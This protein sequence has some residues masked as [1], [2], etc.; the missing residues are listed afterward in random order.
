MNNSLKINVK[1]LLLVLT[2]TSGFHSVQAQWIPGQGLDGAKVS[3]MVVLDSLLF[4]CTNA[5]GLYVRNLNGGE[6]Q[7]NTP[8]G[9]YSIDRCGD[10]LFTWYPYDCY[11]S[12][13]HGGTWQNMLPYFGYG[14]VRSFCVIDT[15]LFFTTTFT[16]GL[17][18][19]S[20]DYGNT[21]DTINHNLPALFLPLVS[22]GDSGMLFCYQDYPGPMY[23][24][25]GNKGA[26]WDSIPTTGLPSSSYDTYTI[27]N[28]GSTLWLSTTAGIFRKEIS[29]GSWIFVQD[30][31]PIAQMQVIDGTLFATALSRGPFRFD[32]GSGQW[33][34]EITGLE[35]PAVNSFCADSSHIYLA[36]RL[37]PYK[38]D[39]PYTWLPF[40]GGLNQSSVSMVSA[41]D[42]EVWAV[43]TRGTFISTDMGAT[44]TLHPLTGMGDPVRLIM[45]DS[46]YYALSH[47]FFYLSTDH[48]ASWTKQ[49]TGL[50]D[51]PPGTSLS[52]NGLEM[53]SDQ[54]F[55]KTAA[56]LFHSDLSPILWTAIPPGPA[57]S[58]I[59]RIFGCDSI[60]F[61][62]KRVQSSPE[63]FASFRS[64]DFG[65]TF[66]SITT[67]PLPG[68]IPFFANDGDRFYSLVFNRIL[69]SQDYGLTW[70]E[71]PVG[72]PSIRGHSLSVSGPAVIV[73]GSILDMTLTDLY[74]AVTY[75]DGNH[76]T[77]VLDNLPDPSWPIFL[78]MET[79][80]QRTFVAPNANGLWYRDG[81]LT[82]I[83]ES[84]SAEAG[85]LRIHPNP[86]GRQACLKFTLPIP[87]DGQVSM[88]NM[89]GELEF[90]GDPVRFSGGE[91]T[92]VLDVRPY[93]PGVHCVVVTTEQRKMVGTF[94]V[95]REW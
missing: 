2:F 75:D 41:H 11:R 59:Y 12:L 79:H 67:L 1:H 6:W 66:D 50:P 42:N 15:S 9:G 55:L 18:F 39:T 31:V 21:L 25:S 54:L 28:M 65:L 45:T 33:I 4:I 62:V 88:F 7:Q 30:S 80:Q 90:Q 20:D 69:K 44:F 64:A 38:C 35:Q 17:M 60:L 61:M 93:T 89:Q 70:S 68:Y 81:L 94:V 56:G 22:A 85:T 37:G 57:A 52:C 84:R 58:D 13:D 29:Q 71:I 72:N 14:S 24:L 36:T 48:G 76:W 91:N 40:Y 87:A 73:C 78:C 53:V 23:F 26:T 51:P 10:A 43:T 3:D 46:L 82:T 92:V 86:A 77:D 34:Q 83:R 95:S 49:H 16:N 27:G 19:R 8:E 5:N 47:G 63:Q 32:P 74:L